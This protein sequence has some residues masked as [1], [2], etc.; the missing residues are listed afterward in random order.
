MRLVLWGQEYRPLG[1]WLWR[2]NLLPLRFD[3]FSA[4]C[5]ARRHHVKGSE[6]TKASCGELLNFAS[7]Q[8]TLDKKIAKSIYSKVWPQISLACDR[9]CTEISESPTKTVMGALAHGI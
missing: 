6:L 4:A 8:E 1:F 9:M 2:L 7:R 3:M 5:K